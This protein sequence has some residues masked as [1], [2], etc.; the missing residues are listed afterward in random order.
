MT[1]ITFPGYGVGARDVTIIAERITAWWQIE[2]NGEHGTCSQ[3]D[4][5]KEIRVRA[6]PLEVDRAIVKAGGML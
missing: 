1:P 3:L 2:Y 4:N 6:W 5:G